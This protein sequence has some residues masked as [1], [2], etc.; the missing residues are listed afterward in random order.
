MPELPEVET[1]VQTLRPHLKDAR[2]IGVWT[3]GEPLRL[4]RPVDRL[5]LQRLC[6]GARA[7]G[8]RRRGKYILIDLVQ[9]GRQVGVLVHLGMTGRLRVQD[10]GEPR[11][12]HTHVVWT[13]DGGREL[14]FV[15]ARRFGWV[16]AARD[17]D[18]LPELAALG[19][20]PLS[21]L[22]LP[23]L[24]GLLA[25]SRA[26]LKTFLLDQRRVAGLGN[27]YVCEALF[28]AR[29]HPRTP[30]RQAVS[31]AAGLLRGIRGVLRAAIRNRGTS[32][33]DFVDS[34]G[35]EG[36]NAVKLLVYGREGEPC[37]C[38]GTPIER[39]VDAGRSTYFCARCQT[40][41]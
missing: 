5:E 7:A 40:T 18:R 21:D 11:A 35:G 37:R 6:A 4:A 16:Q 27:I 19:P 13:L 3:S 36:N 29:L 8:V 2:L 24:R 12:R 33:R 9:Q 17:V 26:P 23:G 22:T 38:C 14:R 15:D 20:D 31:H 10:K 30:A 1:V 28:R 41:E 39:Q 32:L 25:G 34:D